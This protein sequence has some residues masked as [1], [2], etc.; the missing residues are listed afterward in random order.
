MG[1]DAHFQAYYRSDKDL[2]PQPSLGELAAT[3]PPPAEPSRFGNML[4]INTGPPI[5]INLNSDPGDDDGLESPRTVNSTSSSGVTY[6]FPVPPQPSVMAQTAPTLPPRPVVSRQSSDQISTEM[7]NPPPMPPRPTE[8]PAQIGNKET[9][10][11]SPTAVMDSEIAAAVP[12]WAAEGLGSSERTI[13]T[14]TGSLGPEG[15]K[16]DYVGGVARPATPLPPGAAPP[17]LDEEPE[18][19]VEPRG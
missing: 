9:L 2:T 19:I 8:Q 18:R 13:R 6:S 5:S 17:N 15:V 14:P 12:A 10:V 11:T 16:E 4:S 1:H 3:V 7:V